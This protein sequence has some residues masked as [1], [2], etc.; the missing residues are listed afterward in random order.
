MKLSIEKLK[1]MIKEELVETMAMATDAIQAQATG[2][3]IIHGDGRMTIDATIEGEGWT[4]E[5]QLGQNDMAE[6]GIGSAKI[7]GRMEETKKEK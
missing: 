7:P 6:L 4:L 3:I 2:P 1:Q 5:A